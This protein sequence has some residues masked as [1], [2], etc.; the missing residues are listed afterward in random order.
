MSLR[1]PLMLGSG[2][3][4]VLRRAVDSWLQ[5]EPPPAFAVHFGDIVDGFC[6]REQSEAA[7]QAVL[8]QF[9]RLPCRTFHMLGQRRALS[10]PRALQVTVKSAGLKCFFSRPNGVVRPGQRLHGPTQN[11]IFGGDCLDDLIF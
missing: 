1:R 3:V 5:S 9:A 4:A 10:S 6:P 8:G 7:V 11:F 2:C